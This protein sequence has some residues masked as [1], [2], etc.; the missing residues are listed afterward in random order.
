MPM[1]LHRLAEERSIAFH[2]KVLERIHA[3]PDILDRARART[4]GWLDRGEPHSFY[5]RAWARLLELPW[6]AMAAA[7]VED[8]EPMRALRQ[9][10]PFAGA[11]PPKDR[12]AIWREFAARRGEP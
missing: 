6:D 1:D 11:L 5:A 10:T 3:E 9:V 2:R 8:S 7:L 4:R 12:W